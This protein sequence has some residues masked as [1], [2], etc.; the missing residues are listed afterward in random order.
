MKFTYQREIRDNCLPNR[1][2]VT[3]SYLFSEEPTLKKFNKE[4]IENGDFS[5]HEKRIKGTIFDATVASSSPQTKSHY[6]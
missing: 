1:A 4:F 3:V 2:I 6:S 5:C